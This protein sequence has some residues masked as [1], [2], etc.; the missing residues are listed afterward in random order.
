MG[1]HHLA[2]QAEHHVATVGRDQEYLLYEDRWYTRGEL[3]DRACRIAGGFRE[4]GIAPGD[5]VV[6][7]MANAP[8]VGVVYQALWRAGA[9]ATPAIFLLPPPELRH[10][11]SDAGA[12][13]VV[14]SP[15][16][17]PAVQAAVEGLGVQVIVEGAGADGLT[18]LDALA[19][20]APSDVVDRHDDDLAALMYTGGTTGR[21]KGVMLTHAN[22][23]HAGRSGYEATQED[24][25]V[26]RTLVPLPLAHA[27]G[28]V[29]TAVGMHNDPDQRSVLM[30]WF[31]PAATV[32]LIEQHR[33]DQATLVPTMIKM[34]LDQP[35]EEHDLSSL[36]RILSGSAPLPAETRDAFE[37]RVPSVTICE[38]YGLTETTAA[39]TAD[40]TNRRRKGT[41]GQPLPGIEVR[42]VDAAGEEVGTD[43]PGEVMV[44]SAT[45][46]PGYWKAPEASEQT[47]VD[48]WCR[49]GD[50]GS[51]DADG[52]LRILDR[53]KDLIIRGGFNIYP[54]DV[55]DVLH[56]HPHIATAGV[57]GRPDDVYG[58]EIVAFV[59]PVPGGVLD[60]DEVRTW[61]K[62]RLGAK[63]YPR[64]VRVIEALPLTP[65]LKVD[66]K[67][68][69]GLV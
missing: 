63:S 33:L 37:A 28:L 58:E 30:R 31:D 48:G 11:I 7:V 23:W 3:F 36:R 20:A 51:V 68:L 64:D 18:G 12:R 6:V 59:T 8:D 24:E 60:A 35:L 53:K 14:V 4:V 62:E 50:I 54:R 10:I 61:A 66:R 16:F 39:T 47:F 26:S 25:H 46:S 9:V 43:E 42:I 45:V 17:L 40:R 57:V 1:Q 22:L 2:R 27:F 55:E 67:A 21:S 69:R 56:E 44:R 49:T 65:V 29:V 32:T 15:E 5:R 19:D 52:Y 41:V 34:L 13:A 38:G